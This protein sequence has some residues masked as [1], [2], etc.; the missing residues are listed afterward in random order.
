MSSKVVDLV[1]AATRL[2]LSYHAA[3]RLVMTGHLKGERIYG[4]WVVDAEDLE[5]LVR[6]RQSQSEA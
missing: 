1:E 4:K 3:Q 2:Q 6:E 5:R